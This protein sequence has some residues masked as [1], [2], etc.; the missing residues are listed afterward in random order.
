MNSLKTALSFLTI[1]PLKLSGS[2]DPEAIGRSAAWFPLVGVLIGGVTSGGLIL[3]SD[4]FPS[5]LAAAIAAA[6]WAALSGGLHL[7]GLADCCDGLLASVPQ[8]RRIEI[9][10]DPRLGVFGGAGLALHLLVKTAA[11]AALPARY[12]LIAPVLGAVLGRWMVLPLALK[13]EARSSGLGAAF[14]AGVQPGALIRAAILPLALAAAGGWRGAAALAAV[15]V[16]G[17][18]VGALA[19]NRLGRISGDVYGLVVELSELCV[20]LVF[21]A[22]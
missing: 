10:H 2:M 22:Q 18:G 11:L 4:H 1:L 6:L 20:L 19:K 16:L 5:F 13:P 12:M 9:M 8:N 3:L 7:D 15:F 21:A 17:V 14:S